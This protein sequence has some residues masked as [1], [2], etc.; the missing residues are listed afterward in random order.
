MGNKQY[1]ATPYGAYG[2]KVPKTGGPVKP[3]Y[4]ARE[5]LVPIGNLGPNYGYALDPNAAY[6][7]ATMM[8]PGYSVAPTRPARMA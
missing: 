4:P 1:Y 7:G 5:G 8:G 3:Q 2:P 6:G